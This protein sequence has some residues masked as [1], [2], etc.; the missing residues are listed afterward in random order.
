MPRYSKLSNKKKK[1]P[2]KRMRVEWV[3]AP[4]VK[5]RVS[6]LIGKADLNWL[7]A[8]N[9]HCFRSKYSKTRAFARIWGLSRIWQQALNNKPAY[10]IEVVS[11]K[12]DGLRT[13]EMDKIL[14]HE[15]AHIPQNFSGAL[16]PHYRKGPRKFKNR[17]DKLMTAY[18]QKLSAHK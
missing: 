2:S 3:K 16:V 14:F 11:E 17:I 15:L 7:N 18:F 9:I 10:I 13:E 1:N 4:D 12:Y 8:S 6:Y 5:K